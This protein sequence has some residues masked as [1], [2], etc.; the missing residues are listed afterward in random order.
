MDV[1]EAAQSFAPYRDWH[2]IYPVIIT[3]GSEAVDYVLA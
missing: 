2:G 3:I 1:L